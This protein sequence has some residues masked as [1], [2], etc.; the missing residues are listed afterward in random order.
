MFFNSKVMEYSKDDSVFKIKNHIKDELISDQLLL[1]TD[2][3]Q[4][5]GLHNFNKNRGTLLYTL[6]KFLSENF[7]ESTMNVLASKILDTEANNSTYKMESIREKLK[8]FITEHF[9]DLFFGKLIKSNKEEFL[10]EIYIF[11]KESTSFSLH[12]NR[13]VETFKKIKSIFHKKV[14]LPLKPLNYLDVMEFEFLN[15]N[16]L[17]SNR[18]DKW[19]ICFATELG[20][21]I[22]FKEK[23]SVSLSI[24]GF[25]SILLETSDFRLNQSKRCLETFAAVTKNNFDDLD[26]NLIE[27][28]GG[29]YQKAFEFLKYGI[30]NG[31]LS[32]FR[33]AKYLSDFI[34]KM[35]DHLKK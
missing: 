13:N 7:D 20:Q 8:I 30:E 5:I 27:E 23:P 35:A 6:M 21:N 33:N 2:F 10:N 28:D 14:G 31:A 29:D 19:E 9:I 3:L 4:Q 18:I 11:D 15:V 1:F 22:K 17:S 24:S 32:N 16:S 12:I 25:T 34:I 26:I